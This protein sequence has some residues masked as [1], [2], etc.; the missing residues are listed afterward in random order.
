MPYT[1]R[2]VDDIAESWLA[3]ILARTDITDVTEGSSIWMEAFTTAEE[4]AHSEYALKKLRDS[5]FLQDPNL[6][7]DMLLERGQELPANAVPKMGR[8]AASGSVMEL[9]R[10]D[11]LT[12]Q[13][14]PVGTLFRR[15]DGSNLVYKTITPYVFGIGTIAI[16]NIYVVCTEQGATG[17]A[18]V[19]VISQ[20]VN[21]PSWVVSAVNT[22]SITN[23]DDGETDEQYKARLLLYLSSLARSQKSAL[24]FLARSYV[25]LDGS[26]VKFA[27]C[28]TDPK[29]PGYVELVVDDGSGMQGLIEIG[30]T[31]TGIVP[32]GGQ[33]ILIHEGPAS[34]DIPIVNVIRAGNVF[35]VTNGVDMFSFPELG[36]VEVPFD[37]PN[38]LQAG[39]TWSIF[40][41]FVYTGIIAELQQ[42]VNGDVNNP[43]EMPGWKA[44]GIR[45][46]V[47]PP[48]VLAVSMDIH[49]V[50]VNG[51][52]LS[53]VQQQVLAATIEFIASLG[54]GE[55]LYTSQLVGLL[56]DN[57][58]VLD[59]KL[60]NKNESTPKS[61]MY[62]AP[63][64]VLRAAL[65]DIRFLPAV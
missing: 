4:I 50:P 63:R 52:S 40:N 26:R 49:V 57:P 15:N 5:F 21:L 22:K 42:A 39:D 1:P 35:Q 62:P 6:S 32:V 44:E 58:D 47:V 34:T 11:S 45:V 13:T 64:E 19:G 8:G 59:V 46:R 24:E 3:K 28:F 14:L 55:P 9:Y 51:V 38:P 25:A 33:S 20:G 12:V 60:Y 61:D 36:Y 48:T 18:A 23:G 43:V 16:Q 56:S 27:K 31:C 2:T 30:A 41:Y 37:G 53:G 54:P 7:G 17:N 29:K 10:K 65:A